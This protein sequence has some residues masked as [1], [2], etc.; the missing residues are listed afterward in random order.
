MQIIAFAF[1]AA[2]NPASTSTLQVELQGVRN[3]RG[4]IH[5]CL[6]QNRALFPNCDR[7]PHAFQ[8]T[9]PASAHAL[10]FDGVP[11]GTYA[12]I[13]FHDQNQN[14][15]LD[16]L[17]GIPREGFGFGRNPVIRFSAPKYDSVALNLPVGV[18]RTAVRLQ[19]LL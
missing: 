8:R 17:L 19:Y 16:M 9:V 1:L 15:K 7:D 6:T 3:S 11:P 12:L 18:T 10:R 5:A 14:Q 4:V 2:A 13:L